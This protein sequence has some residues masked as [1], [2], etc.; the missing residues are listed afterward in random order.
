MKQSGRPVVQQVSVIDKHQ[1]RVPFRRIEDGTAVASEQVTVEL[2]GEA[3][4]AGI[5]RQHRCQRAERQALRRPSRR[6]ARR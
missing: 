2:T 3:I 4:V 6:R 5:W 1:Q